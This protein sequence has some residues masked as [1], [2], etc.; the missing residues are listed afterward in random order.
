MPG[1]SCVN[2]I[3][4]LRMIIEKHLAV[5]KKVFAVF[6]D[7]EKAYDK[8]NRV[9]LWRNLNSYRINRKLL[10]SVKAVYAGSRACVRANGHLSG[11]FCIGAGVR[12]GC[13]M[14]P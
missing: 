11:W 3:F 7:L 10:N 2:Q 5:G 8:V 4:A 13:A 12:Q 14:S 9:L 1:K 6:V